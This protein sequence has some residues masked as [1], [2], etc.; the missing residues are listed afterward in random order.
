MFQL[1]NLQQLMLANNH[2]AIVPEGLSR[3]SLL[4]ELD[5]SVNTL[6]SAPLGTLRSA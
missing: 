6:S 4:Q 2:I 5:I 3:L 1:T